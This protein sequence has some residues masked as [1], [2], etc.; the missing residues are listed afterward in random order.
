MTI[1]L[2]EDDQIKV[3]EHLKVVLSI[4]VHEVVFKKKDGSIRV[5][6]GT[7]DPRIIGQELFEKFA[8]P[9]PRKDGKP[10]VESVSSLPTFDTEK[11]EWRSFSFVDLIGVDGINIDELLINSQVNEGQ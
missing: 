7:R 3:R 6:K 10:R 11:G 8:S 2:T 5:L 4:G 1:L 9:P